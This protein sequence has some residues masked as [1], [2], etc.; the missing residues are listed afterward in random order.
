MHSSEY[1]VEAEGV[2]FAY[3]TA[4]KTP[5]LFPWLPI[6]RTAYQ[7]KIALH[8]VDFRLR[9][10]RI[11]AL[12]GK[13]GS[14]KT[15]LIKL[16]SGI[17]HL[18]KGRV[19][20]FGQKPEQAKDRIGLCLGNTLIYHRLTGREN[21][22]YYGKLFNASA[23]DDRI[24][25]L[26][27]V[28]GLKPHLDQMVESYSFG[29]KAKLAIA[30]SLIHSPELLILDEPTLGIDYGLSQDIRRFIRGMNCTIL[31]TT[32]YMEEAEY[33]ADDICFIDGGKILAYGTR[34]EVLERY[35][36]TRIVDAYNRAIEKREP[37]VLEPMLAPP[38]PTPTESRL[39][40]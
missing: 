4:Y 22:E 26:C 11:T 36:S 12:L 8:N 25:T 28:L 37:L 6:K 23:L 10:N 31:L 33:L 7:T 15:T 30:R 39:S 19:T 38:P 16:L 2:C 3:R 20:V 18:Q 21:L 34:A 5:L 14:G 40:V 32:H 35:G 9:S 27:D 24:T 1:V 17:R 13:N 29:M